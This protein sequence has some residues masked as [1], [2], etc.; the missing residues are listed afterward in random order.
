ML[1][2]TETLHRVSR[3]PS[4]TLWRGPSLSSPAVALAKADR[5]GPA[6]TTKSQGKS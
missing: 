3:P 5:E 2:P 1:G 6:F 4:L